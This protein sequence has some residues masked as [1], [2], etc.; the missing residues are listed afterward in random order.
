MSTFIVE[1]DAKTWDAA[2]FADMDE[3]AYR[4][5]CEEIF[6]DVLDGGRL[7][8]NNSHW[9]N[10]PKLWNETWHDRRKVL[11]GDALHTAHFSIGSGTR[12]AMEDAIA[13]T[14]ALVDADGD[15]E[16]A[17]PAYQDARKPIVSKIVNAANR[18]ADWY[19]GFGERMDLGA[20]EFADS[21]IRRAGRI[22]DD[23][24]RALSPKFMD[25]LDTHRR[26]GAS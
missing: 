22:D 21:Y 9:R 16:D 20:W 11:I 12:L 8:D 23:R 4:H 18:S 13:L 14:K 25:G 19:E 15:I 10:F 26:R 6:S 1:T 24:L 5:V 7:V 3:P 17:L 2:G